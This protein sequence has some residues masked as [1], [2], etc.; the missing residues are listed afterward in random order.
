MRMTW[1]IS[2]QPPKKCGFS[3]PALVNGVLHF[4]RL[5]VIF[6]FLY[7]WCLIF[8]LFLGFLFLWD[9]SY[10]RF[11]QTLPEGLSGMEL[12]GPIHRSRGRTRVSGRNRDPRSTA[13]VSVSPEAHV[14][15]PQTCNYNSQR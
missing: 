13:V 2:Q 8:D 6:N 5:G 12:G 11:K 9:P 7:R 15:Y 1:E 14:L 4:S 3:F 10:S